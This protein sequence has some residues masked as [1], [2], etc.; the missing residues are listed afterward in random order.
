MKKDLFDFSDF[1][2]DIVENIA[3]KCPD[4]NKS[5]QKALCGKIRQRL[6]T[7]E[8]FIAADAVSGVE[9]AKKPVFRYVFE[10]AAAAVLAL[11]IIPVAFKA[12]KNAPDAPENVHESQIVV[13]HNTSSTENEGNSTEAA[14]TK[15]SESD[16]TPEVTTHNSTM[17]D[18]VSTATTPE[19]TKA[20]EEKEET[21][22]PTTTTTIVTTTTP[23][24][25]VPVITEESIFDMLANLSYRQKS[26]DGIAD[27][28]IKTDNGTTYQI[29]TDCNHVLRN[30]REEADLTPEIH[31]WINKYG[32]SYKIEEEQNTADIVVSGTCGIYGDNLTWTLD[33]EGTLTISGKG[34]MDNSSDVPWDSYSDDIVSVVIEDG[35]TSIGKWAFYFCDNLT[36]ITIPNSVTSIGYSVF[37]YC[38]SLTSIILP[39]GVTSIGDSAFYWCD[40]LT[41]IT[42]P[43][44]V[45]SIGDSAFMHCESLTSITIPDSVTSIGDSAFAD[46]V[47][48]TS[49]EIRDGVTSIGDYAFY[50][51]KNLTSITIPDSVTSIGDWAFYNCDSLTSITIKNPECRIDSSLYFLSDT[52]TIYGHKGST[53]QAYA[54]KHN[55]AFEEEEN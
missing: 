7:A 30:D 34:E 2:D 25:T 49:I 44:S 32:S 36:S 4:M 39:D 27:Y 15:N 50:H 28:A 6:N 12:L 43:D 54:K 47:G 21:T 23:V 48:L 11:A 37:G 10:T 26:C 33:S 55:M 42:I 9:P 41:S 16:D 46:C 35:V 17:N 29:L 52:V 22:I 20:A 13:D 31:E 14:T 24:T 45:T 40:N 18:T 53:A 5:E 38:E 1:D 51:C 8:N 3:Q 19:E